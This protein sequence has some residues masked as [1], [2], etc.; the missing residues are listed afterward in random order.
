MVPKQD[1]AIGSHRI[2]NMKTGGGGGEGGQ[3]RKVTE[4]QFYQI[5][6]QAPDHHGFG[7]TGKVGAFVVRVDKVLSLLGLG[8]GLEPL[9]RGPFSS[10]P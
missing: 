2:K 9:G 4:Q 10:T 3:S 1:F 5:R 6:C 7:C 8:L